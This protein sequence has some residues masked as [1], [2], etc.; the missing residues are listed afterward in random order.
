MNIFTISKDANP[1]YLATICKI[2]EVKGIPNADKLVKTTINGYDLVVSNDTKPGD[3]VIY[4]PV[5]C[6]ICGEFLGANNLYELK[7]SH[8]NA[9]FSEIMDLNT[10]IQATTDTVEIGRIHNEMRSKCGFFNKHGRVRILKLRGEYSQ[11]FI[12]GVESL[13]RAF[14]QLHDI[15]WEDVIGKQFDT[16][17][18]VKI[19][20]KYIP[21]TQIPQTQTSSQ[22]NWRKSMRKIRQFDKLVPGQFEFHYDTTMLAEH[23]NELKPDDYVTVTTKV[24][25]TSVIISKVLCN[26]QL[27]LLERFKKFLGFKIID[28]EY[29]NIY[30]SRRVIKN[31]YINKN[32]G[33][34]FYEKDVWGIVNDLYSPYLDDGMT[35]YGEIVGYVPGTKTF[36]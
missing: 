10:K 11:G 6:C 15:T 2:Q 24:H 30:S 29:N 17:C 4:F 33:E 25:G 12:I 9:N 28:K 3:I 26:K 27:T 8:M 5:E 22:K 34:D 16:C 7:D 36:I 21:Q 19:C 14:P 18:G 35:V 1:N 32:K 23:I 20:K 31:R 13:I